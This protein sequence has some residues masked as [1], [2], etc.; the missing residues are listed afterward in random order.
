[1]L[2][3]AAVLIAVV[4]ALG[5]AAAQARSVALLVGIAQ[6]QSPDIPVLEGPAQDV[7][8]L[9]RVLRQRWDFQAQDIR[10]LVNARARRQAILAELDALLQRSAPGDDVLIYFS[11]HGTSA[12]DRSAR[13]LDVPHGSGAFVAHDFDPARPDAGGLVVGRH[14]LV[15]RIS[16]LEKGGRRIWVVM[17]TCYSGQAVRENQ[18]V[19]ADPDRWPQRSFAISRNDMPER[20]AAAASQ[21]PA[22]PPYPYRATAF[23]AASGEGETAKDIGSAR[24]ARWPSIDGLPHGALT[25]ALLRVLAGRIA[26]DLNG[27]GWLDLNEVHRA[28]SDFMLQRPYGQTPQ[29]LPAVAEDGHGIG[30]RPVLTRRGAALA[31]KEAP[32]QPLTVRLHDLPAT[33]GQRLAGLP[34]VDCVATGATDLAVAQLPGGGIDLIDGSGDR[35]LQLPRLDADR[36]VGQ[37]RQLAW[38]KRLRALAERHRR[39]VLPFAVEPVDFGGN[40]RFGDSV[41]FALRPDRAGWLL[42]LDLDAQGRLSPLYPLAAHQTVALPAGE[43]WQSPPM[44]VQPPEGKDLQ[45]AFLFDREPAELAA[46]VQLTRRGDDNALEQLQALL[47]RMVLAE[48]RRFTFGHSEFRTWAPP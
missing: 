25:D 44:R 17:D 8:A 26:G 46:W 32:P 45:F 2:T 15:P 21:R 13:E 36:I 5:C 48:T 12:L 43:A 16:A 7:A 6:Y 30:A 3:P 4:V 10:S 11:G 14:D 34:G 20:L 9:D 19:G 22:A 47:E 42:L 33:L 24:L 31:P 39:G 23:L 18:P 38:A 28:V 40:L 41:H 37:V 29:R 27:D 1:M 35:W